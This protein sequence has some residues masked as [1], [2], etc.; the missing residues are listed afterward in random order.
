MSAKETAEQK[1]L[2]IIET[3]KKAQAVA[4]ANAP[5]APVVAPKPSGRRF[6]PGLKHLNLVMLVAVIASLVY[7]GQEIVSGVSL[8]REELDIEDAAAVRANDNGLKSSPSRDSEYY[9]GKV[10]QRNI[11][12]PYEKTAASANGET[13][14][15][16]E[17]DKRMKNYK[18]VG[19]AWLDVPES[20]TVMIEEVSSGVTRFLKEGDK[21][22]DVTIKTIYTDRVV[23]G[24]E[25][26]EMVIKL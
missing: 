3:T 4:L 20:A 19:V 21:I 16:A 26:E 14:A 10:A 11:F 18:L 15:K 17:L 1:L 22:E 12:R 23:V 9:L 8:L 2:R 24:H 25:N 6:V 5:A 13:N 7:L